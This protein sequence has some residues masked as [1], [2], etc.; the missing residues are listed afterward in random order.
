MKALLS[1][2]RAPTLVL[3]AREDAVA[4]IAQ[5]RMLA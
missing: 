1:K 4:P 2:V 5:G 3:H